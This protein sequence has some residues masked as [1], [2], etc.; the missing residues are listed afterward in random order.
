[1]N[2]LLDERTKLLESTCPHRDIVEEY[3][4]DFHRPRSYKVCRLCRGTVV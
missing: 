3:D 2:Q 4:D 1:M